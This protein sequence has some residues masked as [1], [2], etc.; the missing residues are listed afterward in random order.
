MTNISNK[1]VD[2]IKTYF[3]FSNSFSENLAVYEIMCKNIVQPDRSQMTI[4]RMRIGCGITKATD[5]HSEY[6]IILFSFGDNY[7]A[8]APQCYVICIAPV[9]LTETAFVY[10]AVLATV[11][12]R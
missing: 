5:K 10:C 8:N 11:H 9:L 1:I 7:Y 2:K 12:E 4:R 6:V 3:V